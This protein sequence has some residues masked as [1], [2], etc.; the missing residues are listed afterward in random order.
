[1]SGVAA[2]LYIMNSAST[3]FP[4]FLLTKIRA[5]VG[6]EEVDVVE[7]RRIEIRKRLIQIGNILMEH[8][9]IVLLGNMDIVDHVAVIYY[10]Y[11][12]CLMKTPPVCMIY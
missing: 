1:M 12:G 2:K 4:T 8:Y 7:V 10:T 3:M 11:R 9:A 5:Y 6:A